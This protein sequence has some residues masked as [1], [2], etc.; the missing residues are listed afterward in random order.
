M[1]LKVFF[2][3]IVQFNTSIRRTYYNNEMMK[4]HLGGR[5][6]FQITSC[7]KENILK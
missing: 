1:N 3:A 7:I 6:L 4:R 2:I 5:Y